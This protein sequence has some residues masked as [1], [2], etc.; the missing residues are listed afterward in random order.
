VKCLKANVLYTGK[1]GEV[2]H[3]VYIVW[4][5]SKIVQISKDKPTGV[6]EVFEY[7][8]CV[9][10]PALID[11]HSHI[12]MV[13]AGENPDEEEVNEEMDSILPYLDALTSI[14]MDDPAFRDSIEY[15]VLYSCVLPGSGNIIGGRAVVIRNFARDINEAFIKY[16]GIKVA[17]GYNPR[18]VTKWKGVRPY[19]RMG[20][21]GLLRKTLQK[22]QDAKRLLEKGKKEIEEIDIEVRYLLPVIEGKEVLRV[23]VH[24]KDDIMVM[25]RIADEFNIKFTVEHAC[26]VNELYV[27]EILRDRNIP[28]VYGPLDSFPY[29]TELKH[30]TWRNVKFVIESRHPCVAIMSDHPVVLQRNLILQL[31]FFLRFGMKFSEAISLVTYNPARI[32]GLDDVLGTVEVGKYASFVVWNK[33]PTSL[34]A[35]PLLVIGEGKVIAEA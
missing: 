25:L 34:D 11:A 17:L 8:Y 24:K 29:K 32:L 7:D 26:D 2:L 33:E 5:D 3:D 1:P 21:V 19:T 23:H 13:R 4:E 6:E 35:Y 9:V 10:T 18:S 20:V 31:R 22:A 15:G 14:Y 27:F 12:G 16:A 28:I 30:E